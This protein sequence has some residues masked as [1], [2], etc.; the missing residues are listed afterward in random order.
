MGVKD[1]PVGAFLEAV[2]APTPTSG[3]GSV[4]A[5]AGA[6]GAALTRMVASLARGKKGYE[7]VESDLLAIESNARTVQA[8]LLDLVE[9]DSRAYG[10]VVAAMKLPKATETERT[11][12]VEAMQA[13]YKEATRVPLETMAACAQVLD[14]AAESLEKGHR[15]AVTDAAVAILL[16]EAGLRGASLNAR[17]N[18]SSIRDD[19]FRTATEA[20]MNRILRHADEVGH[21]AMAQAEGRI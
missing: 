8:R 4:S 19:A 21:R 18:L 12:R 14:L 10:A 16:A 6:L 9:E 15:G 13:A 20:E 11:A 7:T 17:I 1:E 5:F 3:G 2:A